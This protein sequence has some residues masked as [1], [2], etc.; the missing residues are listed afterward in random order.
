MKR[1]VE[2]LFLAALAAVTFA[3]LELG[4]AIRQEAKR[5]DA[6]L[7]DVS[8]FT[9]SATGVTADLRKIADSVKRQSDAQAAALTESTQNLSKI[10]LVLATDLHILGSVIEHLDAAVTSQDANLSLLGQQVTLTLDDARDVIADVKPALQAATDTLRGTA[11]LTSNPDIPA[12]LASLS[13]TATHTEAITASAERDALA[14]EKRL[15]QLLKPAS[16]AKRLFG[17]L[18]QVVP[19]IVTAVK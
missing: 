8:R 6:T 19:P 5:L 14:L 16:L 10:T 11:A 2:V 9:Q 3:F 17:W 7:T 13:A 4:L 1:A 18:L 15:N 12:T